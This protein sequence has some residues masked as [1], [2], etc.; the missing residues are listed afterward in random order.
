VIP[1]TKLDTILVMLQCWETI[2]KQGQLVYVLLE[3]GIQKS[4]YIENV[5]FKI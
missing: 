2:L 4:V 3:C 5:G 1:Q